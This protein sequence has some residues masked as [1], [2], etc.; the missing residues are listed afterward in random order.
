MKKDFGSVTVINVVK[1]MKNF[2]NAA[3]F[4]EHSGRRRKRC[5][6]AVVAEVATAVQK[7]SSSCV[8]PCGAQKI[9]WS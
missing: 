3:S 4:N 2:K 6:L 1:M 7:E 9:L 8:Q 5:D